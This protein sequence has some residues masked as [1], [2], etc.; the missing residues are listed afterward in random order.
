MNFAAHIIRVHYLMVS[1][2]RY[3]QYIDGCILQGRKDGKRLG[4]LLLFY[5]VPC[6]GLERDASTYNTMIYGLFCEFLSING[7]V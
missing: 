2:T 1:H 3:F 6:K 7:E 5:E 4:F